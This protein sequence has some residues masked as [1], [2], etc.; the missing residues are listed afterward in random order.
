VS[1]AG[2]GPRFETDIK[3][4]FRD[5]DRSSMQWAFDLWDYGDVKE[6]ARDVLERVTNGTM[7]CDEAWPP[8]R[9]AVFQS[10][11]DNEMPE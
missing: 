1:P 11:V 3:P 10:W 4:F 6:H 7:P 9:V 2:D 8:E 5:K